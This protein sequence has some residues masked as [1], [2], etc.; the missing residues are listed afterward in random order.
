VA[1]YV[2]DIHITRS[3]PA[4]VSHVKKHLH[5]LFGIK[6]LARSNFFLGLKVAYLW[7]GI[8]LSQN[9]F[10]QEF[11]LQI[12]FANSIPTVTPFLSTV[13]LHQMRAILFI[14]L[15]LIELC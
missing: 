10:T 9:K 11:L 3:D 12:G 13:N 8:F 5:T 14:I 1:V 6:D 2:D 7:D 15:L 4:K